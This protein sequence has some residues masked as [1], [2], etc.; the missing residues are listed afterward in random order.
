MNHAISTP[1]T[2]RVHWTDWM[3]SFKQKSINRE[4]LPFFGFQVDISET[5]LLLTAC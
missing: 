2:T 3:I 4:D 1:E 5:C